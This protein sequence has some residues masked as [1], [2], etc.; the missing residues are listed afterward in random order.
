[1]KN[2]IS[3]W[4]VGGVLKYEAVKTSPPELFNN[5]KQQREQILYDLT[6]GQSEY[7]VL[8]NGNQGAHTNDFIDAL[9]IY[10]S[11]L[12][13]TP[14]CKMFTTIKLV[15][16]ASVVFRAAYFQDESSNNSLDSS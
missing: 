1:M 15:N 12:R 5:L 11:V 7:A 9:E 8:I 4:A 3:L 2:Q 10:E 14:P 16:R 6:T 13:C